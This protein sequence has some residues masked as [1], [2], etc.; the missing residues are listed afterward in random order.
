MKRSNTIKEELS[1]TEIRIIPLLDSTDP[2]ERE[3]QRC[4]NRRNITLSKSLF[5][6][7]ISEF[8]ENNYTITEIAYHCKMSVTAFKKMFA[9]YYHTSPHH[10]KIKQHL[11]KAVEMLLSENLSIKEICYKSHFQNSSHFISRFKREFGITPKQYRKR[12]QQ[13]SH[14]QSL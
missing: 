8:V 14:T 1:K 12:Y 10:W 11:L 4:M 13:D 5:E 9:E 7:H 3:E 6:Q 2:E